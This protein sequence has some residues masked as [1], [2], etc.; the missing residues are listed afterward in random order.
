MTT[1]TMRVRPAGLTERMAAAVGMHALRWA[2]GRA[3]A[4][5]REAVAALVAHERAVERRELAWSRLT[6]VGPR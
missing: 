4:R 6:E 3:A 2:R 5:E 1:M